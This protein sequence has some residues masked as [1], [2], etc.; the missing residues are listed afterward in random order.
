MLTGKEKIAVNSPKPRLF[1]GWYL[2]AASWVISFLVTG[3]AVG[4]FFKPILD[5]FGWDR[6]TLR[7]AGNQIGRAAL[8]LPNELFTSP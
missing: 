5:E 4:I 3:N 6:A 1:Y 8:R 7:P 2:V